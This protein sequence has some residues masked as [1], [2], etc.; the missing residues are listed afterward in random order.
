MYMYLWL[1]QI[2]ILCR[3]CSR[4][5]VLDTLCSSLHVHVM[6]CLIECR[7]VINNLPMH[8]LFTEEQGRNYFI[9]MIL[10]LEYREW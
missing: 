5:S 6:Y 1:L 4:I 3:L 7:P 9:D 10:G 2:A 8:K